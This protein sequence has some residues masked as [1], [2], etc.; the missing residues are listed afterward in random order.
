VG[1][2]SFVEEKTLVGNSI[3]EGV[4]TGLKRVCEGNVQPVIEIS[5]TR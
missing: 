2:N 5:T 4:I 3:S 1:I